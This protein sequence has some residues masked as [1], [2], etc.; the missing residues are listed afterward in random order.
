[1]IN[2]ILLLLE[3][4]ASFNKYIDSVHPSDLQQDLKSEVYLIL[5]DKKVEVLEQLVKDNKVEQF[6]VAI[7]KTQIQSTSSPF[8]VKYRKA[9]PI[10]KQLDS[11]DELDITTLR[12]VDSELINALVNTNGSVKKLSDNT[13]IYYK[14][15]LDMTKEIA[16]KNRINKQGVTTSITIK[17]EL[18]VADQ[19]RSITSIKSDVNKILNN[20]LKGVKVKDVLLSH[21]S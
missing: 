15:L 14:A 4:S 10:Q 1:M 13:G 5:A 17:V 11:V 21:F 3:N 8:Y 16:E 18:K 12:A 9:L 20:Q 19:N 7:A 2:K 6:A